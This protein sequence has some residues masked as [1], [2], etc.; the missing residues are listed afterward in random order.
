MDLNDRC[1]ACG[2]PLPPR[3]WTGQPRKFCLAHADKATPA[4]QWRAVHPVEVEAY[5]A[6]RRQGRK[7]RRN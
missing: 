6:T 7:L 2:G 5:N 1:K 4:R 3:S